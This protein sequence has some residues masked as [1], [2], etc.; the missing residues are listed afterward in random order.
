MVFIAGV[1]EAGKGPVVGP[2]CVAGVAIEEGR[3]SELEGLG[4]KDSKKI[5][6]KRREVLSRD[7]KAVSSWYV[8][9]VEAYSIDELRKVMTM[10]E[11]V[12]R[13]H[14]KVVD[15][16]KPDKV[17][18]DA[19]D[20]NAER[21][22]TNLGKLL[23]CRPRIISEHHADD[24]YLIVSAASIIAKVSRDAAVRDIEKKIGRVIGSGYPSDQKTRAFVAD[25]L[26]D[27]DEKAIR[28]IRHSWKTTDNIRR[29]IHL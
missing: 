27:N 15:E 24:K 29:S 6:K 3:L 16:L 14:A 20:V 7:I 19:A 12:L 13:A 2:M 5:S 22:G 9:D 17:F 4:I 18:V 28:V 10:N 1:D 21:F 8:F 23:E 25:A 11:V 26:K